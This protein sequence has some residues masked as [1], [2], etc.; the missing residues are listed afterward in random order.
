MMKKASRYLIAIPLLVAVLTLL[1]WAMDIEILRRPYAGA[2]EMNPM[3]AL[4]FIISAVAF[5]LLYVVPYGRYP[6]WI[7][8]LMVLGILAVA[9]LKLLASAGIDM[10]I[11]HWLFTKRIL[12]DIALGHTNRMAINSALGFLL[13]SL[14]MLFSPLRGRWTGRIVCDMTLCVF[15]IGLFTFIGFV[16]HIREYYGIVSYIPM[17]LMSAACFICFSLGL[18]FENKDLGF[19]SV[20]S[21]DY[22]GGRMARKLIPVTFLIPVIFGYIRLYISWNIPLSVELGAAMLVTS[23]I[24][25]LLII[26]WFMAEALN[27]SDREGR[28]IELQL[29]REAQ[30]FGILPDAVVYG[31]LDLGITNLNA[32][33]ERL[34]EAGLTQARGLKIDDLVRIDMIDTTR[35]DI[36]KL[37]W[38]KEGSW[39]G[40]S[41]FTTLSGRKVNVLIAIKAIRDKTGSNTGWVGVYTDITRLKTITASLLI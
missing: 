39:Q 38:G 32:A 28:S 34:F 11:D 26:I 23:I 19:M 21:S 13:L 17:G 6:F 33:A 3:T 15:M 24:V 30:L 36:R 8:P 31:S 4:C 9:V 1:G 40:E 37:L 35:E 29:E 27:I 22:I 18:L 25:M 20:I 10:G 41:V 5:F 12:A 16:Y 7:G 2:I 14:S